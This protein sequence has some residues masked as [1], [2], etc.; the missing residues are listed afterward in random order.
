MLRALALLAL[1]ALLA[2]AL[3]PGAAL[4]APD[5]APD[6]VDLV[7]VL[8][9]SGSM[10]AADRRG[11]RPSD[12]DNLR[13]T[14]ALLA[15]DLL[16]P[17]DRAGVV[18]F[19]SG[20]AAPVG[21]LAA[22]D[23]ALPGAVRLQGRGNTDLAGALEAALAMLA[24]ARAPGRRQAVL[25]LTDG[26]PRVIDQG[27]LGRPDQ[28][29]RLLAAARQ[30]GAGGVRLYAVGLGK[31][32]D[33]ALLRRLAQ[34][35]RSP[36]MRSVTGA[37][38]LPDAFM[39]I[40]LDLKGALGQRLRPG[41]TLEALPFARRLTL[42]G[43]RP[44]AARGLTGVTGLSGPVPAPVSRRAPGLGTGYD[45]LRLAAPGTAR[46]A[47]A[48]QPG[49]LLWSV[50]ELAVTLDLAAPAERAAVVAGAPVPVAVRLHPCGAAAGADLAG[51]AAEAV[52]LDADRNPV[53]GAE[54]LRPEGDGRLTGAVVLP[55][56]GEWAVV[57][58]VRYHGR[59]L[60]ERE[61][62]LT[63]SATEAYRLEVPHRGWTLG[64]LPV[65]L[66]YERNGRQADRPEPPALAAA[67]PACGAVSVALVPEG[68][69]RWAGVYGC[70]KAGRVEFSAAGGAA[71]AAAELAASPLA[72][73]TTAPPTWGWQGALARRP[74][75]AVLQVRTPHAL[76]P[77]LRPGIT[78]AGPVAVR[79][80][81]WHSAPGSAGEYR[82][83]VELEP[84]PGWGAP[85]VTGGELSAELRFT[86][87]P[88]ADLDA[89]P[90]AVSLAVGG[91]LGSLLRGAVAA[92][93][94]TLAWRWYPG[95]GRSAGA[96]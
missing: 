15:L 64:A 72:A 21:L 75:V 70:R 19:S 3:L 12:P 36:L 14:A 91:L 60:A 9:D 42:V 26:Q 84:L 86:P 65:A 49:T 38:G 68:V 44:A 18:I 20:V 55:D 89:A 7:L 78:A 17:G 28:E 1:T 45:L 79:T 67:H 93:L 83:E 88:G 16:A 54:P 95:M 63:A 52:V 94:L 22:A 80:V 46:L 74:R 81:R 96:G 34:E 43:L 8:D 51:L 50:A 40:L 5:C 56:A 82:V 31:G 24:A 66:A 77:E 87:P 69:G 23:P 39:A 71:T 27:D 41:E 73:W 13:G 32:A 6:A 30:A 61:V 57:V 58:R 62:T 2:V 92:A 25:L 90:V 76:A 33:A 47:V 29:R 53:P 85:W 11:D 48:A 37:A 4:A 10:A 59:A 35:S